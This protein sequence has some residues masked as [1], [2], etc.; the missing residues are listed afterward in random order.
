MPNNLTRIPQMSFGSRGGEITYRLHDRELE[1]GFTYIN[2]SRIYSETIDRWQGGAG[3]TDQEKEQILGDVVE[4]IRSQR[5]GNPIVVINSDDPSSSLWK[6]VCAQH[7]AILNGVEYTSDEQQLQFERDMYLEILRSGKGLVIDGTDIRT[8][9]D[10]DR[11][12]EARRK[13]RDRGRPFG[14]LP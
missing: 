5:G 7:R 2:G 6:R 13:Q 3:L 1:V 4:F 8:D 11:V 12:L 14:G 10:I 9:Q